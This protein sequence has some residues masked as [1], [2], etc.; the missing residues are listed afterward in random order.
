VVPRLALEDDFFDRVAIARELANDLRVERRAL[1]EAAEVFDEEIAEA[2]LVGLNLLG[3]FELLVG[4]LAA[5]EGGVGLLLETGI[6][7]L[8][9]RR[10][11]GD[12]LEAGEVFGGVGGKKGEESEAGEGHGHLTLE[13][14]HEVTKG[15][16]AKARRERR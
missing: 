5:I 12:G 10:L 15:T 13:G 3:R 7:E 2:L 4:G 11:A 6:E 16:K 8:G 9:S 1:G 14:N